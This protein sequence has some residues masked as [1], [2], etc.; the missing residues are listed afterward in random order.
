M[1]SP[2][3]VVTTRTQRPTT[4]IRSTSPT[5]RMRWPAASG[6]RA[7]SSPS[8]LHSESPSSTPRATLSLMRQPCRPKGRRLRPSSK[9]SRSLSRRRRR[10][11]S[12]STKAVPATAAPFTCARSRCFSCRDRRNKPASLVLP[13]PTGRGCGG[14]PHARTARETSGR[15]GRTAEIQ[16]LIGRSL[17]SVTK[18]DLLGE[19]TFTVDCDVLKADGGTRTASI[20]GAYVALAQAV[21]KLMQAEKLRTSPLR[22]AVAAISAGIV[23]GMALLDLN[24]EEDFR[25]AADFNMVMTEAG[26]FPEVQGTGESHPFTRAEMNQLLDLSEAGI[27]E[28]FQ[29]QKAALAE[30]GISLPS[31]VAGKA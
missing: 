3:F 20:T 18:L 24:Y 26:E 21:H 22:Y 23:D 13:A 25:A 5:R 19:R 1:H 6:Y 10:P 30:A 28:L 4:S 14:G 12:G 29:I 31:P 11:A 15:S 17:R 8:R 7:V 2:L 9:T 16:R 27:G